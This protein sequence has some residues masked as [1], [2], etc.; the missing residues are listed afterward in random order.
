LKKII[1]FKN[2]AWFEASLKKIDDMQL[3][4]QLTEKD[5]IFSIDIRRRM[6]AVQFTLFFF[7]IGWLAANAQWYNPDKVNSKAQFVYSGAIDALREGNMVQGKQLLHKALG[8]DPKFL[9]AY[10]SLGGACGQMKQYD[11]AVY[12]YHKALNLDTAYTSEFYLPYSINLAGLGNF[13]EAQAAIARFLQIP[14]LDS[15]SIKSAEYRKST[16]D[17]AIA[18]QQKFGGSTEG[19]SP[20]NLGDSINSPRSEYYPSFTIND[21]ILVFTRRGEGIREDFYKSVRING[22]YSRAKP[23]EGSLNEQ[24]SK[25]GLMISQDGDWLIFAGNFGGA[26]YGDFDLYICYATPQ[27][28]SEPFN[29]EGN[30]NTEFW[31][32][33][34]SLSPDKQVLYFS[35][36]RAGGFGGKDLYYSQRQAS[37]KWGPAQ[38]MGPNFNTPADE[39]APFIHADNQTLYFTS[40]GHPGYGGSDTYVSRKGPGGDWSIPQN[41][42]Y[43][44]N[45]ID[46]DGSLSISADGKTAFFSSVRGDGRGALDLYSFELPAYARPLQTIWVTGNVQDAQTKKGLPALVDLV[47]MSTGNVLEKVMT[48]ETGDYLITLP[49]GKDYSFTVNRKGYLFYSDRFLLSGK[50]ADSVY[51]KNILLQPIAVNSTI[52]LKDILFETNSFKLQPVSFVEL[53]KLVQLMKENPTLKVQINGHT[54]NVGKPADNLLL[55]TNR[56]K[57]VVDYLISKGIDKT[58]LNAKGFGAAKPI[59]DNTTEAGR[60]KNRRTELVVVGL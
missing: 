10:L 52:E 19:F 3:G 59:A 47:D 48:N 2:E 58:R 33:S 35:S 21:S 14:N 30:V 57:A 36:N 38:N 11:S 32:S 34:P 60:A 4:T 12:Y 37:G 27:G 56:A 23:L 28:W 53:D 22:V 24:P 41:L 16:Y 29:M 15:R 26:G 51:E 46:D 5:L 55:S 43:P 17:F 54:D 7:F 50:N 18:H 6:K 42:G 39:L 1:D 49:L 45:T 9:D 44:V 13:E 31:E 40:G 25:G 20:R 8:L